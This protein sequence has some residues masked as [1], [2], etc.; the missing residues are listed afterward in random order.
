MVIQ[1][2][3]NVSVKAS[4]PVIERARNIAVVQSFESPSGLL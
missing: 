4:L 3:T 2:D 1:R